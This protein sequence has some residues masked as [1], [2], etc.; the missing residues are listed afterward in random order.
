ML[1]IGG[2]RRIGIAIDMSLARSGSMEITCVLHCPPWGE[3][4]PVLIGLALKVHR[5]SVRCLTDPT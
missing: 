1:R 4:H 3:L 2:L 5:F